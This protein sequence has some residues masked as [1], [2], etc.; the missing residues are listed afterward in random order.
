MPLEEE[1]PG[2][3]IVG[4]SLV[5]G[6]AFLI[7]LMLCFKSSNN[8]IAYM[9]TCV[10]FVLFSIAGYFL[11]KA[12]SFDSTHWMASEE[13]SLLMGISGVIWLLSMICLIIGLLKFAKPSL[14]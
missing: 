12:I 14:S 11:L 13:I 3:L 5:M 4:F 7:I 10:H 1:V 6:I 9:W 2:M 8:R